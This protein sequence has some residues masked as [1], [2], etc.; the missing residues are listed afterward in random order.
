[1]KGKED[2]KINDKFPFTFSASHPTKEVKNSQG[3]I[4]FPIFPNSNQNH[5]LHN[6]FFIP[7]PVLELMTLLSLPSYFSSFLKTPLVRNKIY[8]DNSRVKFALAYR[9]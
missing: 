6:D 3:F 8:C 5:P 2:P 4:P 1:M 9:E 7:H